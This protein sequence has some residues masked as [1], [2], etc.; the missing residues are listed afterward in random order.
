MKIEI[1][2]SPHTLVVLIEMNLCS[3]YSIERLS[4][5]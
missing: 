4:I 2:I 3:Y 5:N 1:D